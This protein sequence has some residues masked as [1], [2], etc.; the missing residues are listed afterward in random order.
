MAEAVLRQALAATGRLRLGC[1]PTPLHAGPRLPGG[2]RL[3]VKRDDLTGLG[4]GGN[5]VRKLEFLCADALRRGADTLVTVGAAQ[6]NHARLTAAAGAVLGMPTHLVL[7]G[8]RPDAVAGNQLLD[9]LFGAT[10][11]YPGTDDWTELEEH[12]HR[13][14][15]DLIGEGRRPY[16]IAIGGSTQV[17]VLGFIAGWL[18]LVGQCVDLAI[19]PTTVVHASSSGGTHAGLL[20]G[21]AACDDSAI[22]RPEI[23]AIGVAKQPMDLAVTSAALARQALDALGLDSDVPADTVAVDGRWEGDG[24][25]VP[26]D[27]ADDAIRWAAT[28]AAL[29]LDRV[30]TGKA[31]AGLLGAAGEGRWGADDTVVFWHTG[32]QPAIFAPGGAPPIP[33]HGGKARTPVALTA[34]RDMPSAGRDPGWT[35]RCR[36]LRLRR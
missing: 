7:G 33:V 9:A 34:S 16:E 11:H 10:L 25:A 36:L 19:A 6:S 24:Y 5:K 23:V 12:M 35:R 26:T 17:G 28:N 8:E 30:Y 3:M 14:V 1:L 20:A 31:F 29:V 13:L 21:R 15:Q 27:D 2:A 4:M 18:E 22:R 32:G